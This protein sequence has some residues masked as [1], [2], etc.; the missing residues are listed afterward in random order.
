MLYKQ[1][2]IQSWNNIKHFLFYYAIFLLEPTKENCQIPALEKLFRHWF[3]SFRFKNQKI[4]VFNLFCCA[5]FYKQSRYISFLFTN[6][7]PKLLFFW[8]NKQPFPDLLFRFQHHSIFLSPS[9][10]AG[11]YIRTCYVTLLF[12]YGTFKWESFFKPSCLTIK[13]VKRI[14]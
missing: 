9:Y 1:N 6:I 2:N 13:C 11:P 8:S 4:V 3:F 7:F 5:L 14:S 10:L 12:C